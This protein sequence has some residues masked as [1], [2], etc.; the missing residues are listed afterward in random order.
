MG[1][2]YENQKK[3][4]QALNSYKRAD[5][6]SPSKKIKDAIARVNENKKK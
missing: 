2:V 4:D 3:W 5:E 6:M 1:Y